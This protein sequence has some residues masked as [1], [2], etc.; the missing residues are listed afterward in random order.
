MICFSARDHIV[1]GSAP[2]SSAS[3][4]YL[5]SRGKYNLLVIEN[6]IN[7]NKVASLL[8]KSSIW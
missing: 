4:A 1:L 6:T 7:R 8:K 2:Y 3:E 5:K